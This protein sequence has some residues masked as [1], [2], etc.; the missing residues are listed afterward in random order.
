MQRNTKQTEM[1]KMNSRIAKPNLTMDI[2]IRL[3]YNIYV[4]L[5]P[6]RLYLAEVVL[7]DI[8]G[9]HKAYKSIK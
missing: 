3:I 8:R 9:Y 4:G 7:R 1:R 5:P 6:I 2:R